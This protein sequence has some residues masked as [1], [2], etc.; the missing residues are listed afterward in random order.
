MY[1]KSKEKSYK[2]STE[3]RAH[4]PY[5]AGCAMRLT[6]LSQCPYWATCTWPLLAKAHINVLC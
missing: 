4:R 1:T 3:V 5:E 2:G 6:I